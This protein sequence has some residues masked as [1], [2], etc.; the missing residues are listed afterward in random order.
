MRLLD[1]TRDKLS[2]EKRFD[3]KL[4][5]FNFRKNDYFVD[6]CL[7]TITNHKI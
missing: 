3:H 5:Y 6:W 7:D 4:K 1:E 2:D